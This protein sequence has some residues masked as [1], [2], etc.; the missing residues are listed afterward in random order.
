MTCI[1]S[2]G[3]WTKSEMPK[4]NACFSDI[5]ILGS[6]TLVKAED[7]QNKWFH[8]FFEALIHALP[9]AAHSRDSASNVISCNVQLILPRS[10][11]DLHH[12]SR[13]RTRH[14]ELK[15]NLAAA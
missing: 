8:D 14:F 7:R 5:Y 15:D 4:F 3:V 1:S 6:F 12:S 11:N 2:L 13:P 9:K 10:N